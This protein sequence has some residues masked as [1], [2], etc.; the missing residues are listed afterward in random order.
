ME[1]S[2]LEAIIFIGVL[3]AIAYIIYKSGKRE[4]SRKGYGVG[5]D[6]GRKSK[7]Q[8]GCLLVIIFLLSTSAALAAWATR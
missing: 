1:A 2:A 5:F 3:V 4:G 7:G 8:S 6:R